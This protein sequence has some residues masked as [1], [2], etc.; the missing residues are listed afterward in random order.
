MILASHGIIG[1]QVTQFVG[2][3]DFYPNAAAAYSLRRLR[4]GYSGSAIKV[5][6]TNLDEMDIGFDALGNL[7][8]SALLS[9]TGTGALDNGFV[10]KWYDQSGNA[11][12]ATQSTASRQP[13]IV[14]A[15]S[16]ILENSKPAIRP[17]PTVPILPT[18]IV[19]NSNMAAFTVNKSRSAAI[20]QRIISTYLGSGSPTGELV[21]DSGNGVTR[22]FGLGQ[23]LFI[24]NT[25]LYNL[26]YAQFISGTSINL[27]I[28]S[29]T[30]NTIAATQTTNT[31]NNINLMEDVG[32]SASVEICDNMQEVIIYNFNQSSNRSGIE[33]NINDFYSI[34]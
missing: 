2:L 8:T 5:R 18:P 30:L 33:T 13:Q 24:N 1:S 29:N 11:N 15:G 32:N 34:Y 3:L 27:G 22:L 4:G 25:I 6:R 20:N 10:T 16:V 23:T 17:I 31:T 26:I 21:L 19:A 7:D 28:N 12:D 14:I 9:F